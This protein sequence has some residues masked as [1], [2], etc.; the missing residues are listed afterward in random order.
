MGPLM[1]FPGHF[2]ATKVSFGELLLQG[3][4][5]AAFDLSFLIYN[6]CM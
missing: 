6:F 2:Q 1:L 5:G 4:N 3:T